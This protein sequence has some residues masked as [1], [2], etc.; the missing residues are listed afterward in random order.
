MHVRKVVGDLEVYVLPLKRLAEDGLQQQL[1]DQLS[2]ADRTYIEGLKSSKKRSTALA[3]RL[4]LR[5]VARMHGL[6]SISLIYGKNG[7]PYFADH[8]ELYFNISH[9]NAYLILACSHKEIG[10]DIE[11]VR[12]ELPK[13]PERMLSAADFQ[14]FQR[15]EEQQKSQIFFELWTRKESY[16]K[17]HGD[18]IFRKAKELSVSDGK[19]LLPFMG[20]PTAYFHTCQWQD[21]IISV[22]TLEKKSCISMEIVTPQEI[23]P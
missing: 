21:Y 9:S 17:L 16:I 20:T 18:S 5:H 8:S 13:F 3:G 4:L 1:L 23:I 2:G 12:K 22:C 11:Q 19:K 10:V 14:F 7:K 15:Q 6:D